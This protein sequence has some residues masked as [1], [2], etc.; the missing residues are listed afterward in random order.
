MSARLACGGRFEF[1]GLAAAEEVA[2][3]R[4]IAAPGHGGDRQRAGRNGQ[5]REFLQV[6]RVYGC[7]QPQAHE[8]GALTSPG[9]FE[10]S[11]FP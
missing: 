3:V 2:R 4:T 11:G 8:Y 10:H 1:L 5:L 9:A 6:L 7:A